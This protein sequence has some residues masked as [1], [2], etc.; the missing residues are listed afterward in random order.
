MCPSWIS[1]H[2]SRSGGRG[3]NRT[4]VRWY[5]C[6]YH[7]TDCTYIG[8]RWKKK[9]LQMW[10]I[11]VHWFRPSPHLKCEAMRLQYID[12]GQALVRPSPHLTDWTFLHWAAVKKKNVQMW[13]Q[14]TIVKYIDCGQ[15]P[16]SNYLTTVKY[17]DY[18][19]APT[20]QT[21]HLYTGLHSVATDIMSTR[22]IRCNWEVVTKTKK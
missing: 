14:E 8:L 15:A 9:N 19:Q 2:L 7:L 5:F 3:L 22:L 12:C 20:S 6:S 1:W 21:G 13:S 4:Y 10:G 11:L 17:I 18:G 16:T